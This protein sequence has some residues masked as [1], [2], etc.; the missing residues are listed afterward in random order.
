MVK[1]HSPQHWVCICFIGCLFN[2]NNFSWIGGLGGGICCAE[3]HILV[4]SISV[5][6]CAYNV[7]ENVAFSSCG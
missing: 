6:L 7:A 1:S 4:D 5:L 3:C 2:S